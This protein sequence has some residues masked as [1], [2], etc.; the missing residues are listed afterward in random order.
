MSPKLQADPMEVLSFEPPSSPSTSLLSRDVQLPTDICFGSGDYTSGITF[1]H[2]ITDSGKGSC[3]GL[4]ACLM[5]KH[6]VSHAAQNPKTKHQTDVRSAYIQFY[7]PVFPAKDPRVHLQL[8]EVSIGKAWSTF[9]V[10]LTQGSNG[11]VAVS[12]D[13]L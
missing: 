3:G 1:V 10:E 12:A 13:V 7:R 4:L 8:R 2:S 9:R 5:T 6:A 11:K